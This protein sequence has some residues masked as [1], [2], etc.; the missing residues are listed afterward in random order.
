MAGFRR[1]LVE[2]AAIGL[3]LAT[4]ISCSSTGGRPRESQNGMQAGTADTPRITV[5]MITH[6]VPGNAF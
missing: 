5:A 2:T 1:V 6:G 3:S 4:V